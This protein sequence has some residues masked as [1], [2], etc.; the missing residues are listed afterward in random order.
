MR[1]KATAVYPR[2]EETRVRILEM[3]IGLFGLRGFDGVTTRMIAA[4]ASVP[5]PSLRYY[6]ESKQ[7]LFDACWQHLQDALQAVMEPAL[8]AAEALLVDS[9]TDRMKL[10]DA[11][12]GLQDGL[13]DHL[14][15]GPN[16]AATAL[17]AGRLDFPASTGERHTFASDGR[18]ALRMLTCFTKIIVRISG[19]RLDDK[20]ALIVAGLINGQLSTISTKRMGLAR[21]GIALEGERLLWLKRTIRQ[22]TIAILLLTC[23]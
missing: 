21:I 23:A 11:Y 3:A 4:E 2:G 10:I 16:A 20:D 1:S 9:D 18:A 13:F 5:A 19:D 12:C 6:F 8:V 15:G 7:G 14:V 22:Q 17:F